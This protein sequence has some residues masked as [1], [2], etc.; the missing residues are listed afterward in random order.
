MHPG[1]TL[2]SMNPLFLG[3]CRH[4]S[5][6]ARALVLVHKCPHHIS[7]TSTYRVW[8]QQ[9]QSYHARRPRN[10]EHCSHCSSFE[11]ALC[12]TAPRHG[13][14]IAQMQWP[15]AWRNFT[16]FVFLKVCHSILNFSSILRCIVKLWVLLSNPVFE[17]H[18]F[19]AVICSR[20]KQQKCNSS[21]C[22]PQ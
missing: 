1:G 7:W 22:P 15:T 17:Y 14:R 8:S 13:R 6:S 16:T 11:I 20:I 21:N 2:F 9:Q 12:Q 18:S 10:E 4:G 19:Y 3:Q 5:P